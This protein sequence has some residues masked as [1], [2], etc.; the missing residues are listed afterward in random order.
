MHAVRT[1]VAG[2]LRAARM[3]RRG[4]NAGHGSGEW[5]GPLPEGWFVFHDV[6]LGARGPT[7]DHLVIGPGGVFTLNTKDLSGA[8]RVNA[9]SVAHD[10]RRTSFSGEGV[11]RSAPSREPPDRCDRPAGAGPGAPRDPRRRMD[12]Q[13]TSRRC[14]RRWPREREA[15]DVA[16]TAGPPAERCDRARRRQPRGR[17]R[18]P[19][20]GNDRRWVRRPA[21]SE[22]RA[23]HMRAARAPRRPAVRGLLLRADRSVQSRGTSFSDAGSPAP[24]RKVSA[25][26]PTQGVPAPDDPRVSTGGT[27]RVLRANSPRCTE[28]VPPRWGA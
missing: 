7:L 23:N 26:P 27:S 11:G 2:V 15:L 28:V 13:A 24:L 3:W 22:A 16:A 10:G 17:A 4:A 8:I 12:R 19:P 14:L 5:L 1:H 25:N 21:A 9:R 6:P 18:G 20:T